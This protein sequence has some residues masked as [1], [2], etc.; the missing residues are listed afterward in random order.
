ME[1]IFCEGLRVERANCINSKRRT[2]SPATPWGAPRRSTRAERLQQARSDKAL[3]PLRSELCTDRSEEKQQI[4]HPSEVDTRR[5]SFRRL[6]LAHTLRSSPRQQPPD[7]DHRRAALPGLL[8]HPRDEPVRGHQAHG[9]GHHRR[10]RRG[11][12]HQQLSTALCTT[13]SPSASR[14]AGGGDDP[15]LLRQHQVRRDDRHRLQ[16]RAAAGRHGRDGRR[17]LRCEKKPT[18]PG[19][20]LALASC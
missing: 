20:S 14:T 17:R 2:A 13:H 12:Q 7:A 1:S 18:P 19:V 6:D 3:Y 16:H 8:V 10:Q 5:A 11:A 15:R 9:R 4:Q